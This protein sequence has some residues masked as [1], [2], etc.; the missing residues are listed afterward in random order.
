[1]TTR[2]G[3]RE[4]TAERPWCNP[5]TGTTEPAPVKRPGRASLAPQAVLGE[6]A[7]V[8]RPD[9]RSPVRPP[10]LKRPSYFESARSPW[11]STVHSDPHGGSRTGSGRS[12]RVVLHVAKMKTMNA[13]WRQVLANATAARRRA[14]IVG[15]RGGRPSCSHVRR[16]HGGRQPRYLPPLMVSSALWFEGAVGGPVRPELS[17]NADAEPRMN[18]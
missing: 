12:T 9:A 10:G 2:R 1:M 15:A 6:R 17:D 3:R 11:G 5:R 16:S 4:S 13:V 18:S 14:A 7:D 8:D